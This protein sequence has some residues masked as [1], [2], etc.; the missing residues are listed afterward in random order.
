MRAVSEVQGDAQSRNCVKATIN[1]VIVSL[2]GY[3]SRPERWRAGAT[4]VSRCSQP[5]LS[6]LS[7][8]T[9]ECQR[10]F[11]PAGDFSWTADKTWNLMH[12]RINFRSGKAD[13]T[14]SMH[15]Y[16]SIAGAKNSTTG[17]F[18]LHCS[19][20]S[21]QDRYDTVAFPLKLVRCVVSIQRNNLSLAWGLI[22][23]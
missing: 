15:D 19:K 8:V 9:E 10:S 4:R 11:S 12:H 13:Q 20:K 6:Q 7:A 17:V 1:D 2:A 3:D 21:F 23:K 18:F 14:V 22:Y 5:P 16:F